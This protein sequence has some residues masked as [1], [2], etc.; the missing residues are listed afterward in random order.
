MMTNYLPLMMVIRGIYL[1]NGPVEDQSRSC[2]KFWVTGFGFLFPLR[3]SAPRR[4][5]FGHFEPLPCVM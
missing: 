2:S 3:I 1:V 4:Y 5:D